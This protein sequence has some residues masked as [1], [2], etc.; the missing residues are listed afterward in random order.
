[1]ESSFKARNSLEA[2]RAL[3]PA[4]T[5]WGP[6]VGYSRAVRVGPFIYVAGTTAA[7]SGAESAAEGGAYE[8]TVCALQRIQEALRQLGADLG[9][10]VRTRMYVTDIG[11]WEEIGRAHG[12]FFGDV[13][14]AATMVEVAALIEPDLLVEIE[15]DAIA[16]DAP[17]A[18]HTEVST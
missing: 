10:V 8:Q 3:V 2:Q 18:K 9:D 6:A 14:P 15:A 4:G 11:H 5:V 16:R 17:N 13:R 7:A 12:E 1:M